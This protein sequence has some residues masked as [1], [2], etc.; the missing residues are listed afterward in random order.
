MARA[1]EHSKL[2]P[3]P[4]LAQGRIMVVDDQPAN[5]RAVST[6]LVRSGYEVVTAT[7]GEEALR[8]ATGQ[9]PDLLL[10]DMMMPGMDGFA[11]L[12]EIK[13]HPPLLRLPVV[14]LTAAHDRELLLR[15]FDAGA[16]DYVT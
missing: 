5:L 4:A 14:F 13:Q 1:P 12:A 9:V 10:L 16:V 11:L 6:L 3:H 7:T 8:L 15:A 2:H